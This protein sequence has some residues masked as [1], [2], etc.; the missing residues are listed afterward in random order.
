MARVLEDAMGPVYENDEEVEENDTDGDG[1]KS[2]SDSLGDE[3]RQ[4]NI[5]LAMTKAPSSKKKEVSRSCKYPLHHN[6]ILQN[7][8]FRLICTPLILSYSFSFSLVSSRS[9]YFSYI[10]FGFSFSIILS[11]SYYFFP[12]FYS[13]S[14]YLFSHSVSLYHRILFHFF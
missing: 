3:D 1:Y 13:Y 11:H 5:V 8:S 10:F 12:Q 9:L 4:C 6:F 7:L 2:D 14:V